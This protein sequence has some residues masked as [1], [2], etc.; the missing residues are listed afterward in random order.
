MSIHRSLA[1]VALASL[2]LASCGGGSKAAAPLPPS[3]APGLLTGGSSTAFAYDRGAVAAAHYVGPASFGQASFDVALR[4]RDAAGLAAYAASVSDPTAANYRRFLTPGEIADRFAATARDR[5]AVIA[6]F[7]S[8]GLSAAGWKQRA[9]IRVAGTQAALERAFG[10]QFGVYRNATQTFLAP[11]TPP[12]LPADVPV[13]GSTDIVHGLKLRNLSHY[14][15]TGGAGGGR[16]T[17]YSPQ[18]LQAAFD[19]T[20]AYRDG[21]TGRGIT[22]GIIG[23]GPIS[24]Q[25]G[26]RLGDLEAYKSLYGVKG[27][28][29]ITVISATPS[30]PVVNGAS[31]F[32]SPPPVT[33]PCSTGAV[34][35]LP[36]SAVPSATCNPE[37]GETQIDTEQV[38]GLAIDSPIEYFLSYNPSDGCSVGGAPVQGSPCPTGTGP[39]AGIPQQG[40]FEADEELQ[41]AIDHNSSDILSLSYGGPEAANAGSPSPPYGFVPGSGTVGPTGLDPTLFAM[42]AAEGI[43]VFVASGDA[44]AQGCARPALPGREDQQCVSYPATDPSVVAVGGVLAPLD[45]AGR[46]IG[47]VTTWGVQTGSGGTGG[48]V[49]AYFPLPAFQRVPGVVGTMRNVPDLSLDADPNTGVATIFNADASLGGKA[50]AP[51]ATGG[52]SVAAPEMAAM[53]ALVL[54]ACRAKASCAV[55]SGPKPYR[56]GNPNALFYAIYGK[57]DAYKATFL[58]VTFGNN[59]LPPYCSG[60]PPANLPKDCP[61]PNPS[62]SPTPI[63]APL[64]SGFSAGIGY[65]NVTGLG[66]PF[67]RALIR[68]VVGV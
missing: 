50:R 14:A 15:A 42:L 36:P 11:V 31:G 53:W 43:A 40:L 20:G 26:T 12:V 13:I 8:F 23:T 32:A 30:D 44:G 61:T 55:A 10:T 9:S 16:L 63:P 41:T 68:A 37:D 49:S 64:D 34:P 52:T 5:D 27:A 1:L 3:A 60:F 18:Q 65:D 4:M 58:D 24:T 39:G 45:A 48:G 54:Q 33:A 17:G 56:L 59:A 62:G 25:T 57:P 2:G 66:V 35:G 19:F 29:A 6:Y 67:A 21:F 38:G 7:R 47:P 46:I 28:S 51:S 22:V